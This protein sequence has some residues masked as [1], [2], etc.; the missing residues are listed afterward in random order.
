MYLVL[1]F[2]VKRT[3]NRP[4]SYRW[5]MYTAFLK[6]LVLRKWT[7][8]M[9]IFYVKEASIIYRSFF[10][11]LFCKKGVLKNYAKFTGKHL[12]QSLFFKK[13]GGLMPSTLSKKRLW[14]L[15][16]NEFYKIFKNT[17]FIWWLLLKEVAEESSKRRGLANYCVE[18][19]IIHMQTTRL[20]KNL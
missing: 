16:F 13:V 6:K 14:Q 15:F 19:L 3:N 18:F 1:K 8:S 12:C 20:Y 17:F 2:T 9:A 5:P 11:E 4:S 10:P 7:L